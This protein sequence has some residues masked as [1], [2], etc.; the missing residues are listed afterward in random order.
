MII[1]VTGYHSKRCNFKKFQ[2]KLKHCSEL[3]PLL[4][5]TRR[6]IIKTYIIAM[7]LFDKNEYLLHI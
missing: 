6:V 4:G 3:K 1:V 5:R 7:L 2:P